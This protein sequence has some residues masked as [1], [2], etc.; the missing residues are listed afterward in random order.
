MS[1]ALREWGAVLG[2]VVAGVTAASWP[3]AVLP[4]DTLTGPLSTTDLS[5]TVFAQWWS[6]EVLAGRESFW[7]SDL[8]DFPAGLPVGPSLWN[9]VVLFATGWLHA[10]FEPLRAYN[11]S[12]LFLQV[13]NG[14]ALYLLGR[15]LGGRAGGAV[16]VVLGL[17]APFT[18]HELFA[19]RPEQ[20]FLAPAAL[21][22]ALVPDVEERPL[23]LGA[24]MALAACCYWLVAPMLALAT[25][26]LL[27]RR[28]ALPATRRGLLRAALTSVVLAAPVALLVAVPQLVRP[29]VLATF[30]DPELGGLRANESWSPAWSLTWLSWAPKQVGRLALCALALGALAAWRVRDAR[31]WLG[32][33]ALGLVMAAGP[34]L[35][36]GGEP[37]LVG[38]YHLSLPLAWLDL[39]P[40]MERQW[41]PYR[42]L[43]LTVL[44]LSAA[45]AAVAPRLPRP[46]VAL[47]C[48]GVVAEGL[49][50][51]PVGTSR[52][53]V[54]AERAA[55]DPV[56]EGRYYRLELVSELPGLGDEAGAVHFVSGG[57][58]GDLPVLLA[59]LAERPV[60]SADAGLGGSVVRNRGSLDAAWH[61]R[62]AACELGPGE[63]E[64]LHE[65]GFRW[66]VTVRVPG[67]PPKR[68]LDRTM[69]R[70][71]VRLGA[72][73]LWSL[74]DGPVEELVQRRA[75]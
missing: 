39:L 8:L 28:L 2:L 17:M 22:L 24:A 29:E 10:L 21:Y 37:V 9:P 33:G 51:W 47:L 61:A 4:A 67:E 52:P 56:A 75:R 64:A 35:Q 38:G 74:S 72:L 44:G 12:V 16:A 53:S 6:W 66:L 46:V 49:A 41:W 70:A 1:A 73:D 48:L 69:E 25:L 18:W 68:C 45:A 20:G 36:V 50:L 14:L 40:G 43:V 65:D 27:G 62:A 42:W 5:F 13:L 58:L 32:V 31:A 3:L 59:A 7:H 57:T 54:L 19:G 15:R 23:R 34:L 60:S 63:L 26:V 55:L 11:L 71:P 30:S